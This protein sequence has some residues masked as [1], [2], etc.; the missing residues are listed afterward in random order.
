MPDVSGSLRLVDEPDRGGNL[1]PAADLV[2][3]FFEQGDLRKIRCEPVSA[4]GAALA[5]RTA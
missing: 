2:L 4:V 1:L 5:E 3:H